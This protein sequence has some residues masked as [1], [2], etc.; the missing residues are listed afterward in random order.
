MFALG[1]KLWKS[2]NPRSNIER[3]NH[4]QLELQTKICEHFTIGPLLGAYYTRAFSW[5]KVPLVL[6]SHLRHY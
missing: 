2:L 1:E 4:F 6:F 5:L 3:R